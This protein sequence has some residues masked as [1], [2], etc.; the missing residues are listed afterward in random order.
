MP[1]VLVE[2]DFHQWALDT[3]DAIQKRQ[4]THID[5]DRVAEEIHSLGK[6]EEREIESRLAQIMYHLLKIQYQ[7][8][9]HTSSWDRTIRSQRKAIAALL[10]KQP[11]LKATLSDPETWISAYRNAD[12]LSGP[13][14]L[15]SSV[16]DQFPEDCPFN[17]KIL[18]ED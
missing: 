14:N 13:E 18:R 3:A 4:F 11:S 1:D 12:S 9:R 16:A 8:E 2:T 7:P 5:W 17:E 15:P 6:S 10:K